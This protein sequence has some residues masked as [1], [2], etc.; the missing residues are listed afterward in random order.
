MGLPARAATIAI[1]H[2]AD[3]LPFK[4][5]VYKS[6]LSFLYRILPLP[7]AAVSRAVFLMRYEAHPSKGYCHRIFNI[8]EELDLPQPVDLLSSLPS[9]AAWMAHV[10][11]LLYL[12][13]F[14]QLIS[15]SS[16]MVTLS[17]TCISN[18]EHV[19]P[20]LKG[21]PSNIISLFKDDISTARLHLFRLRVIIHCSD[22]NGDTA[23]FHFSTDRVRN[24]T[25]P[26]CN[27][28]SE[29][30]FHFLIECPALQDVR[31][32]WFPDSRFSI[33]A[34]RLVLF[35]HIMEIV[36]ISQG[37]YQG[38][39]TRFVAALREVRLSLLT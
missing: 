22:L 8:L 17:D 9:K 11:L 14:D 31:T 30:A 35:Q 33:P 1:H 5:L 16:S 2:L 6:H 3:T 39:L 18:Q 7:D 28:E 38:F 26:L 23:S 20:N 12:Q 15:S 13:V 21:K 25:C 4:F 34:S 27:L 19:S 32:M 24:S 37:S 29:N 10:K 36:W